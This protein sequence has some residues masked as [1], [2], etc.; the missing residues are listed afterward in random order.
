MKSWKLPSVSA[1]CTLVAISLYL[2]AHSVAMADVNSWIKPTSGNWEE[3]ASWSLGVLPDAT[4]SIDISN[5][6]WKAVA[7]GSQ[8][9][10]DFPQSMT[11][12]SVYIASPTNSFNTLLL[13]F[14]GFERSFKATSLQVQ[15]N[16]AVVVLSSALEVVTNSTPDGVSGNVYLGGSFIQS[17][18]SWV[19]VDRALNIGRFG[20][21]GYFLTNG[22]LAA[23]LLSVG[24]GL[25][26]PL[27]IFAQYGGSNICDAIQVNT[28]GECDI[29]GGE[30]TISNGI[31]VGSGDYATLSSFY[32]YGG[33]INADTLIN[34]HCILNGGTITGRMFAPSPNLFQRVDASILQTG[35]TNFALSLD[36]GHPNRFGG[37]AFYVLSNGVLRVSSSVSFG[38][39]QFWQ[40]NGVHSIASNLVMSGTDMGM[41]IATAD[42]FL[43]GGIVSSGGLWAQGG[44][45]GQGGGS[46][47]IA[48]DLV[49][50]T[51]TPLQPGVGSRTGQY[52]LGGGF[53]G[54]NNIAISNSSAFKHAGGTLSH[55][56]ML[57]LADG[58][59]QTRPGTQM[60]GPLRLASGGSTYF[61]SMIGF[62]SGTSVLRF[63]NSSAQ[64]WSST[65]TLLVTNWHGSTS[66]GGE[67]QLFFGS[68]ANGLN[69]QQLARIK[70]SLNDTLYAAK[71]LSSGEVVPQA[72]QVAF[73]RSGH[74][75]TLQWPAGSVLQSA[76]DVAGPYTDVTGATS[77]YSVQTSEPHRFFRLRSSQ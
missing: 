23:G 19:K 73:S 18:Y 54:V 40:Y 27:G 15:P 41:G 26:S 45:F 36:L 33:N 63:A 29:Y 20:G 5:P 59:W 2:I 32:Q 17:D 21:G 75:L 46:N 58:T 38:G 62:P 28:S 35:G 8:T 71:I 49:L 7:I 13:N 74:T 22:T 50:S 72:Q 42:Y 4:Q 24:G 25:G 43:E 6:G 16:S 76:S 53:L 64:P 65:S 9:A 51:V 3:S 66:G 60:L 1:R 12:Q 55:S 10:R 11:V 31:T 39:G 44:T 52:A 69:S 48:G 61:N 37:R 47:V 57:T 70:F 67:S 34:G 14:A 68:N 30:T 77:P 56:G